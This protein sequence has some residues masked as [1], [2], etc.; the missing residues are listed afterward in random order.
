LDDSF[1]VFLAPPRDGLV[2]F[3]F[4]LSSSDSDTAEPDVAVVPSPV[5]VLL[6]ALA[7]NS[8]ILFV[9]LLISSS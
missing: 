2:G 5:P 9:N 7:S 3:F 8:C 6:P 4:F 1:V